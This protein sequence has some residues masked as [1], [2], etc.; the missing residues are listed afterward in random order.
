MW[1][2]AR[3]WLWRVILPGC[4]K[5]S[6]SWMTTRPCT[7]VYNMQ[8]LASALLWS[9]DLQPRFVC[10]WLNTIIWREVVMGPANGPS[11]YRFNFICLCIGASHS[12]GVLGCEHTIVLHAAS[13]TPVCLVLM[14]LFIKQNYLLAFQLILFI[15]V[16]EFKWVD[17]STPRYLAE[18]TYSRAFQERLKDF[19]DLNRWI[20]T[21]PASI[22]SKHIE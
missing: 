21:L 10:I 16:L 22:Y 14:F 12:G 2:R 7:I 17:T 6:A 18:D 11:L 20:Y 9:R 4:W 5:Y 1:R 8:S 15:S 3:W 19:A 13:R